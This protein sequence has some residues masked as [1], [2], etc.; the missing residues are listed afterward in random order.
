MKH[1]RPILKWPHEALKTVCAEVTEFDDS[2]RRLASDLIFTL[3]KSPRPGVGLSANQIG[4][5]RRVFLMWDEESG[6]EPF[7]F[8][9]PVVIKSR[10]E[11][12]GIEGC[13]SLEPSDDCKVTRAKIINWVAAD[14][15]GKGIR[16]KFSGFDARVFLH[17]MDHIDGIMIFDRKAKS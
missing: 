6:S 7:I 12:T 15:D 13:L 9:N 10:G 17:E 14:L 5:T 11:Q 1:P 4:D 2:L 3:A 8:V 16:G